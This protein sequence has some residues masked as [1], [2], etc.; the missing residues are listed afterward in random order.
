MLRGFV[1]VGVLLSVLD[2]QGAFAQESAVPSDAEIRK[3]LAERVGAEDR[4]I[5]MVVGVIE[6]KGRRVIA[7]GSLAK[8]DSRPL[9]GD[10]VFEIG[11]ITKVFTSLVLMDMAR[12]GE[13]AVTDPVAKYLPATVKVPERNG[14][15]IALQDLATQS[16]GLPRMPDNF[17]PKDESNPY[18]DYTAEQLYD[19]LSHY[20]LKRDIGA[21]FEY[22]NL[23]VGLLGQALSLRAGTDYESML[24][25]RVLGPLQMTSTAVTLTPSMKARL[26]VG[27]GPGLRPV[28]NWDLAVLAGAGALRST[29]NDMLTFLA[30]NLGYTKTPLADAMADEIS[31]R[32]PAGQGMEIAYNW[33]IQT[34]DGNTIIWH[35]GGTGGYRSYMGFD[36]KSRVG[37]VVLT[38]LSANDGP[39]DIGRHL[40]DASYPL[41]KIAPPQAHTEISLDTQALDKL[42]GS[43]QVVPGA[44]MAITREGGALYEQLTGQGKAQIFPEGPR[45]F[46]LKVVD[47]QISFDADEKGNITQLVLH[48]GGRD[49]PFQRLDDTEAKRA[50]EAAAAA[51]KHYKDQ[52]QLPGS[53]KAARRLFEELRAAKPNYDLMGPAFAD[54]IRKQAAQLQAALVQLGAVQTMTFKGV[55]PQGADIFEARFENGLMECRISLDGDGKVLGMGFRPL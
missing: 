26:A 13:V 3:I 48:Q 7:Y 30:A 43:Y 31:I 5:A 17:H 19:F 52:T 12:K 18:A 2:T 38:N 20:E 29:A 27:H 28:P 46:F 10:T 4:G 41:S 14:K 35:N 6:P 40:I 23:G 53:E 37:V 24:K 21:E 50:A 32:R 45:K 54:V 49:Q 34:K 51:A 22:S 8:G 39:E 11:S 1:A 33:L 42:A 25:A 9:N 44:V 47:A 15:K 55:G 36:P 16:S